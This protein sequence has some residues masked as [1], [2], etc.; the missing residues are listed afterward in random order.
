MEDNFNKQVSRLSIVIALTI[1]NV[2]LIFKVGFS[3]LITLTTLF[4][5]FGLSFIISTILWLLFFKKRTI[6]SYY[7]F[8]FCLTPLVIN[9]FFLFNYVFSNNPKEEVYYFTKQ[10]QSVKGKEHE[11]SLITLENNK[12]SAFTGIRL[13]FDYNKMFQKDYISYTFEDGL[14]GWKVVKS[15]DFFYTD[16][17]LGK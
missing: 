15:V 5:I 6:F 9:L 8:N 2:I 10:I 11:S 7:N 12:Y 3:T 17:R 14:L 16:K 1:I 4:T 13:F